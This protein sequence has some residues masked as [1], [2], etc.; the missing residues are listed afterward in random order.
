[1]A[2]L[3]F[4]I[5]KKIRDR[6]AQGGDK[7]ALR[8]KINNVWQGISWKEFG[9]NVDAL[10]LALLG[11]GI[12][13]QDKIGIISNNMP[14]WTIADLAALQIRAVTVPLYPTN[15]PSSN[16]LYRSER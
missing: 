11:K 12:Q 8:H 7:I 16:Q 2:N 13:P 15:T 6:I 1:M 9:V 4:H 3:D 5:V 14:K 10:S